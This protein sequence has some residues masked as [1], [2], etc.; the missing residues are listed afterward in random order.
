M[1]APLHALQ[2]EVR[3]SKS[4]FCTGFFFG[5]EIDMICRGYRDFIGCSQSYS[6][7]VY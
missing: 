4:E 3:G 2:K 5:I 7:F 1:S 6:R